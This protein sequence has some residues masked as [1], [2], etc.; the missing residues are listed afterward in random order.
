MARMLVSALALVLS[1][2]LFPSA[3]VVQQETLGTTLDKVQKIIAVDGNL[4]FQKIIPGYN[5]SSSVAVSWAVPESAIAGLED[6]GITVFVHARPFAN[7]SWIVID[8][9]GKRR[10]EIQFTLF[11]NVSGGACGPGSVLKK[12]FSAIIQAPAAASYPHSDALI[13]EASFSPFPKTEEEL[14]EQQALEE[15]ESI[16]ESIAAANASASNKS[17]VK[18]AEELVGEAKEM[19]AGGAFDEA[20]SLVSQANQLIEKAVATPTPTPTPSPT[21]S[22]QPSALSGLFTSKNL[23]F[24]IGLVALAVIVVALMFARRTQ[25]LDLD[26][27]IE[28]GEKGKNL[29]EKEGGK[30]DLK[31]LEEKKGDREYLFDSTPKPGEPGYQPKTTFLDRYKDKE[32]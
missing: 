26:K 19:L 32:L 4:S 27:V 11:C 25:G 3:A 21:T 29:L 10:K 30:S 7:D 22:P 8:S 16:E 28:E 6:H 9:E 17:L 15:I 20:L 18:E 1:I 14:A 13:V 24:I 12:S 5:Y 2:A 23:P 31:G